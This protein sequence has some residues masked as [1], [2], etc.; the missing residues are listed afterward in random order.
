MVSDTITPA[1]YLPRVVD[2]EMR[3]ALETMPAVLVEGPRACGKTWTGRR[4]ARS[5]IFLDERVN[6]ALSAG[7]DPGGILDGEAPR[8]LDE[9]QLAP[10]IWNPMRRACDARGLKGQFI[11]TGSAN[12]P[13]DITRHSGAGRI[14]RVRMH[15]MSLL[16]SGESD[17]RLSLGEILE[18]GPCQAADQGHS[19]EH[20]LGLA[21]RGGWPQHIGVSVEA[22][23][24]AAR[25]YLSEITRT[26]VSRV[27]GVERNP[28]K[29]QRLLVSL[30][31]NVATDVKHT[32]LAADTAPGNG[33]P[34]LE[35][36][37]VPR[38][39]DALERLF[40]VER[41]P[42][43]RPHLASRI[44]ARKAPKLHLADPSL[45]VAVLGTGVDALM[46]DLRFAGRLF[47]SMVIRD[48]HVYAGAN[49]AALSHYRDSQ[50]LEVD[51]VITQP[52]GRWA[53]VEVKLGG[54]DAVDKA[55]A[56][57]ARLRTR[58]DSASQ[59]APSRLIVVTATGYA[60]E[61]PDGVCVIPITS[62]G[63]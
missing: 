19:L 40:V 17:G 5:A 46:R 56:S 35:R 48:L 59:G 39:L 4:F 8:L 37:T 27:D 51:L 44:Q 63:P 52:D 33:Q 23:G 12:P 50:G 22:A 16:E 53:A 47:E 21:C 36:R 57:L 24:D 11:L 13:D 20:V 25:A 54:R 31:R 45:T 55:A 10:G 26:D 42:A 2:A 7:M 3:S 14:I 6:D 60:F 15:P 58:V 18:G 38:Y 41:V 43:W 34:E 1:G 62:L 29:V 49:R 9:W 32:T 61:R 28:I 30:A